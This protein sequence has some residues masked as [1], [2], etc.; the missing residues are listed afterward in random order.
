[1]SLISISF[2]VIEL[3]LPRIFVFP[4]CIYEFHFFCT[5]LECHTTFFEAVLGWMQI[6]ARRRQI[7]HLWGR[8]GRCHSGKFPYRFSCASAQYRLPM[9]FCR[10]MLK[11]RLDRRSTPVWFLSWSRTCC[12]LRQWVL[13]LSG[14]CK[15]SSGGWCSHVRYRRIWGR[16][17]L[18]CV[19]WSRM[20]SWSAIVAVHIL[21]LHS[22]HF[23][24]IILCV[25][26][27]PVVWHELLNPAWPS[28]CIRSSLRYNLLYS[29]VVNSLYNAGNEQIGR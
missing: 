23:C 13:M 6:R 10:T 26:R 2:L 21:I 28:A 29:I 15:V 7:S 25:A 20:P 9:L 4:G 14:L 3:W 5:T 18:I 17:K 22:W 1:M 19:W 8:Q 24:S 27:W 16:T 12:F 11:S